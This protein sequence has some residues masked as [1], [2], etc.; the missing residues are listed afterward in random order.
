MSKS[1]WLAIAIALMVTVGVV[2]A[3][4]HQFSASSKNLA[5]ADT[6][7]ASSTLSNLYATS[8]T[9]TYWNRGYDFAVQYPADWPSDAINP[10]QDGETSGDWSYAGDNGEDLL[11]LYPPTPSSSPMSEEV[12]IGAGVATDTQDLAWCPTGEPETFNGIT[13]YRN[14]SDD[15]AAGVAEHDIEYRAERMD[16]CY[17]VLY[18]FDIP[19]TATVTKSSYDS[20][21]AVLNRAILQTFRFEASSS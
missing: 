15:A 2:V 10:Q 20:A 17:A 18:Q 11:Y 9:A 8:G 16:I 4:H 12:E 21:E 6:S 5:A 1:H 13:F 14:V 7:F 19:F 3:L